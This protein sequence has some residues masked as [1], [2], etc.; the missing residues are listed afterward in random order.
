MFVLVIEEGGVPREYPLKEGV[1]LLG[2]GPHCDIV[3]RDESISRNHARLSVRGETLSVADLGSSN[4]TF[5]EGVPVTERE[6]AADQQLTFGSVEAVVSRASRH[7]Q[8]SVG[9]S[10]L[11]L[12][13]QRVRRVDELPGASDHAAA[14]DAP[15][16]IRLLGETGR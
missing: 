5:C 9:G 4:G 14:L 15:R 11:I 1:N 13:D 7:E 3:L 6:I 10:T 16:L 2:R 12:A 8:T